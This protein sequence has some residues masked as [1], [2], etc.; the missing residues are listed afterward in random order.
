MALYPS[1]RS[2]QSLLIQSAASSVRRAAKALTYASSGRKNLMHFGTTCSWSE[3]IRQLTVSSCQ[4]II[5]SESTYAPYGKDTNCGAKGIVKLDDRYKFVLNIPN[6]DTANPQNPN[7]LGAS[8]I[9]GT[10]RTFLSSRHEDALLPI[11][12]AHSVASLST[13]PSAK[14]LA[15]F[16][17]ATKPSQHP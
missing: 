11:E 3:M 15:I 9:F 4:T 14:V 16:A 8:G 12:L 10:L 2:T 6:G 7:V 1:G 5:T 17:E 13:H